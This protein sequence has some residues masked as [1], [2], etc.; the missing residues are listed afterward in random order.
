MNIKKACVSII[1]ILLGFFLSLQNVNA[2][3]V[4]YETRQIDSKQNKNYIRNE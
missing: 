1:F 2:H 3:G 4:V